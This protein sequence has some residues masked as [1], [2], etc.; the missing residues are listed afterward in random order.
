MI[1]KLIELGVK[2]GGNENAAN[3][4]SEMLSRPGEKVSPKMVQFLMDHNKRMFA[5]PHEHD[6]NNSRCRPE[7]QRAVE[8]LEHKLIKHASFE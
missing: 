4:I 5:P 7:H 6:V 3:A 1:E 2:L 8:R